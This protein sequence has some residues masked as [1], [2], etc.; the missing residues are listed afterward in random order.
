MIR[1]WNYFLL[2]I[3]V[4]IFFIGWADDTFANPCSQLAKAE[5][6]ISQQISPDWTTVEAEFLQSKEASDWLVCAVKGAQR[7]AKDGMVI[8]VDDWYKE[9][10]RI[11]QKKLGD[12][13][14]ELWVI[15]Y[16][17]A[18]HEWMVKGDPKKA[19]LTAR[20]ALNEVLQTVNKESAVNVFYLVGQLAY[21]N[22][23]LSSA[24]SFFE[25]AILLLRAQ[26]T[27]S[28]HSR[29]LGFFLNALGNAYY[30]QNKYQ[31]AIIPYQEAQQILLNLLGKHP[32]YASCIQ[33]LAACLAEVGHFKESEHFYLE[34]EKIVDSYPP[35][36]STPILIKIHMN[37]GIMFQKWDRMADARGHLMHSLNLARTAEYGDSDMI[38]SIEISLGEL[39]YGMGNYLDATQY[40]H[41]AISRLDPKLD[42]S[43]WLSI[44]DADQV[45]M[46]HLWDMKR[47]MELKG[48][49]LMDM[50]RGKENQ[51][52]GLTC[53]LKHFEQIGYIYH[54]IRRSLPNEQDQL[55]L[56]LFSQQPELAL[57]NGLTCANALYSLTGD[58]QFIKTA[59]ELIEESKGM[60][61]YE[62]MLARTKLMET[63][64]SEESL[65]YGD[66]LIERM[67]S[68]SSRLQEKDGSIQSNSQELMRLRYQ[69]RLWHDSLRNSHPEIRQLLEAYQL[70]DLEDIQS[71]LAQHDGIWISYH[72][73]NEDN[74]YILAIDKRRTE[75]IP[76]DLSA[77]LYI[78]LDRWKDICSSPDISQDGWKELVS[79][80]SFLYHRLLAPV[81]ARI[82]FEDRPLIINPHGPVNGISFG[83]MIADPIDS[84]EG[85]FRLLPYLV[86]QH[87]ISYAQSAT[88]FLE[89]IR[90]STPLPSY[91]CLGMA[92]SASSAN[93]TASAEHLYRSGEQDLPGT[94]KEI[95]N[96]SEMIRGH[97]FW[98]D[99]AS[100][101]IFR[102][103]CRDANILHL[104]LHG[105]GD[106]EQAYLIFRFRD[107]ALPNDED[108]KLYE[109]ELSTM[110]IQAHMAVLSACETAQG[111][112]HQNEGLISMARAF[113]SAGTSS[114]LI[115]L[116]R[117]HDYT[118]VQLMDRFYA[119]LLDEKS[120]AKSLQQA[121][122]DYLDHSN[123]LFAHPAYWG[124]LVIWGSPD[125]L[126]KDSI[127]FW[128]KRSL[129][130]IFFLLSLVFISRHVLNRK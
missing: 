41:K 46:A 118:S 108:G 3:L 16:Y 29:K 52:A 91:T 64:V 97:Y 126:W 20:Q 113:L 33:N 11:A 32:N 77:E 23:E 48:L 19:Y 61:G 38:P 10:E 8:E 50:Y 14:P 5:E 31:E 56:P 9:I 119:S 106:Q 37:L 60:I 89:Q 121:Q 99:S 54:R 92:Y 120:K 34:A 1:F 103:F 128:S 42:S 125:H 44:P 47:A 84:P 59:F 43:L 63:S 53:A 76:I 73:S 35:E 66:F 111:Q 74:G 7:L 127:T 18:R 105:V 45:K 75:L 27:S 15:H 62:K 72:V 13:H 82:P 28:S 110:D 68:L 81:A 129:I 69:Y 71:Y 123:N 96:L 112:L 87:P 58:P 114:V 124:G 117:A 80:G 26:P 122:I 79:T 36:T 17:L 51:I 100:E 116:W 93:L 88:S 130:I 102:Q 25:E 39:E 2:F 107:E 65:A 83:P 78:E 55:L 70:A 24:T 57:G 94:A 104:A 6:A 40:A 90:M 22:K 67:H 30:S 109:S 21:M 49:A 85:N 101:S 12:T 86:K 4:L 95:Q 115:N 98:G